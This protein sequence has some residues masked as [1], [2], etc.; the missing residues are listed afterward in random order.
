MKGKVF[1]TDDV[2]KIAQLAQIPLKPDEEQS[3]ALGFNTTIA[4]VNRLFS[5]DVTGV[6]PTSQVTGLVNI[7]REDIID[8]SR[9]FTQKEALANARRTHNGF[10]VAGQIFGDT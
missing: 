5:I 10:F 3:L 6:E 1:T 8:P 2:K 7:Y 9:T 4:L